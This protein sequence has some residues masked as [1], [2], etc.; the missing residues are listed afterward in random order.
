VPVLHVWNDPVN[1]A[2]PASSWG[3]QPYQQLGD[4]VTWFTDLPL[5]YPSPLAGNPAYANY[6][7][8]D[9]YQTAELFNFYT[10]YAEMSDPTKKSVSA[11]I[12]WTKVGQYV[13]FM[14]MGA[15]SGSI[16]YHTR[17]Q[18]LENGWQDLPQHIRDY[19]LARKPEYQHAPTSWAAGQK[20]MTSWRYFKALYDSGKYS[21]SCK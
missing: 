13:P 9:V 16:I 12:S 19:V 14:Q 20:N 3:I 4:R 5:A 21:P 7:A 1:F 15:Q 11:E 6:S 18:K 2:W 8:G 10:S 17:G